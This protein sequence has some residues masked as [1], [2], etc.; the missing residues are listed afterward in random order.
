[1]TSDQ[2]G[3][4]TAEQSPLETTTVV[5]ADVHLRLPPSKLKDYL[6]EPHRSRISFED[7]VVSAVPK[8]GWDRTQGG[9]IDMKKSTEA[10]ATAEKL[11]DSIC[12]EFNVDYPVINSFARV[13]M[14]PEPEFAHELAQ[15]F[16]DY[17]LDRF[18]D[19]YDHFHGLATVATQEPNK[20]AEEIDRMGNEDQMVGV[21]LHSTGPNP[22][23]GDPYYDPIYRAAEDNDLPIAYHGSAN[24]FM[25]EFPRQN[26]GL[27]RYT[28]VHVLA[29]AWSQ[30][31]TLTSI[32]LNGTPVKFPNLDFV[33][34]E[35]GIGWVPY[36]MHRLNKDYKMRRSDSPLLEKP[37][38]EYIREFYFGTQ[39]IGEPINPHDMKKVI[40]LVGADSLMFASD[41]P[42]WDFDHP[43]AMDKHLRSMFTAEER[44]QVLLDN[45]RKVFNLDI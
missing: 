27:R 38:E 33:F 13:T 21:Y 34:L 7:T 37:P 8:D 41:F 15:G 32:V 5:D 40:E 10:A 3:R 17:I 26:Q 24:G 19:E 45:P 22:P 43:D 14:F 30:M 2:A 6:D 12:E 29:H 16:N 35:S 39:P 31:L 23:L 28:A 42:H 25:F 18:L 9:K 1:M 36:M 11:N 4:E 44:E 20:A